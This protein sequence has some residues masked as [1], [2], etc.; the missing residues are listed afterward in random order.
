MHF[1][2]RGVSV[3]D[4]CFIH[5]EE[6]RF[7]LIKSESPPNEFAEFEGRKVSRNEKFAVQF[8]LQLG[9]WIFFA[10]DGNFVWAIFE[11]PT[12]LFKTLLELRHFL[13]LGLHI[14]VVA[15]N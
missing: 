7:L 15:K 9:V 8:V 10:N 2:H 12:R 11:D 4:D 6:Q 1:R 5:E 13:L 14:L 3:Q